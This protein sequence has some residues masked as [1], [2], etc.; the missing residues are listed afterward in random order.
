V[1]DDRPAT[2]PQPQFQRLRDRL[3][4]R[5][6]DTALRH[7]I[8]E[9]LEPVLRHWVTLACQHDDRV[10][11]RAA[12]RLTVSPI[13]DSHGGFSFVEALRNVGDNPDLLDVIG[14]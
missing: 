2:A 7:D 6:V 4:G 1:P 3:A 12:L 8:P 10:A 5:P 9:H 11:E 14:A 13:R